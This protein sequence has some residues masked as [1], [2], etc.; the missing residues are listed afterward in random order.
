MIKKYKSSFNITSLILTL[1]LLSFTGNLKAQ[2]PIIF[3][4]D[5]V[6]LSLDTYRG[7][8][9]WQKAAEFSGNPV[10]WSDIPG[11]TFNNYWVKP[12]EHTYYRAKVTEGNCNPVVYSPEK[13]VLISSQPGVSITV[14]APTN[15]THSTADIA[16][17]VQRLGGDA[18]VTARGVCWGTS[19]NPTIENS[20]TINGTG[21]GSFNATLTG[22][23][24]NTT[25]YVRGYI[26]ANN[27]YS[28][29]DA[30]PPLIGYFTFKTPYRVKV[31]GNIVTETSFTTATLKNDISFN[32]TSVPIVSK[33]IVY[34]TV[35]DYRID[36]REPD[37]TDTKT[38]DGS[39][40]GSFTT[41]LTNL[42]SGG[43]Y[44]YRS[45]ATT[46]D[47]V[48]YYSD[49]WTFKTLHPLTAVLSGLGR[50]ESNRADI[51]ITVY[52]TGSYSEKGV[53][54]GLSPSPTI[55]GAISQTGIIHP[56]N[57]N[58]KYYARAYVIDSSGT[59][60]YGNEIPFTTLP[61]NS[62]PL[63]VTAYGATVEAGNVY[64]NSI[65]EGSGTVTNKGICYDV[66]EDQP[67]IVI[68]TD[69]NKT[70]EGP[71]SGAFS[72]ALKGL[73]KE[74]TYYYRAYAT[75]NNGTTIYSGYKY[76]F[77]YDFIDADV[78]INKIVSIQHNAAVF[79]SKAELIEGTGRGTISARGICYST[80]PNPSVGDSKVIAANSSGDIQTTITGLKPNTTYYAKAYVIV[81]AYGE[82][83][84]TYYSDEVSFTTFPSPVASVTTD[85]PSS[86]A[87]TSVVLGGKIVV[88]DII[89]ERGICWSLSPSPSILGNKVVE[90]AGAGSFT[91]TLTGL[92][93]GTK[94]YAKA[95][96]TTNSGSAM[97][98]DEVS[99]TTEITPITIST[100]T[101]SGITTNSA[102]S[103]GSV[104]LEGGMTVNERGICYGTAGGPTIS[105]SKTSNGQGAGTYTSTLTSLT[106][107]TTYYVRAYATDHTNK[108]HYGDE[109]SFTTP[110]A[111]T[112]Q[113]TTTPMTNI[114]LLTPTYSGTSGGT[115]SGTG[116]ISAKGVCWN[117]AENPTIANSKTTNGTGL[118]AFSS[119]VTG[120]NPG[121][122]YY[123]RAYA[124]N[125]TGT[126]VYGEQYSV[127]YAT[128]I[129]TELPYNVQGNTASSGGNIPTPASGTITA[130]GVCWGATENPTIANSKTSD[131]TGPGTFSS[132]LTGLIVNT[133][134]Y[135]RAY[136]TLSTGSTYYGNQ[137]T[138]TTYQAGTVSVT[139]LAASNLTDFSAE[140][141]GKVIGQ[142][143]IQARGICYGTIQNPSLSNKVITAYTWTTDY[144]FS[145]KATGLTENTV[146]YARAYATLSNGTTIYGNQV[147]FTTPVGPSYTI[148]TAPVTDIQPNWVMGG[149]TYSGPGTITD[150]GV[151]FGTSPN[152]VAYSA[153][154]GISQMPSETTT[155]Q[156]QLSPLQPNTVYYARAYIAAPSGKIFYGNQ[157]TFTSGNIE[158]KTA[159]STVSG[160][161][162]SLHGYIAL[163]S[164]GTITDKGICWSSTNT[165]PTTADSKSSQ[166]T[167]AGPYSTIISGLSPSTVYAFRAYAI[168]SSGTTIYGEVVGFITRDH[169]TIV[170]ETR[171]SFEKTTTSLLIGGEVVNEGSEVVTSRG[172]C[173]DASNPNPTTADSKVTSGSGN[174]AFGALLSGLQPSTRYYYRAYAVTNAGKTVY[175]RVIMGFTLTY[176][177]IP[178]PAPDPEEPTPPNNGGGTDGG[179]GFTPGIGDRYLMFGRVFGPAK[180]DCREGS[181]FFQDY[182]AYG[183]LYVEGKH[184]KTSYD[185]ARASLDAQMR[186]KYYGDKYTYGVESSADYNVNYR[187]AV[188]IEY[189]KKIT[190]WDCYSVYVTIGYGNSYDEALTHALS[191]KNKDINN[192]NKAPYKV[193]KQLHW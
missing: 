174:G 36:K 165:T 113:V 34:R 37:L 28:Y 32:G 152:P 149:G 118:S 177:N 74:G 161:S 122:T 67:I 1:F 50:L 108:T 57:P 89:T 116:T 132:S 6:K 27:L 77:F 110:V 148:T 49:G 19:I 158:V 154:T 45:Y 25:Y 120:L 117:T 63:T 162:A 127:Y 11:A 17:I 102:M 55:T 105:N 24:E 160:M 150:K 164:G 38:M 185:Q 186:A 69:N 104:I 128:T 141:S 109:V 192:G 82:G 93:P 84:S 61:L 23:Q 79:S 10:T 42:K 30:Q 133:T 175:G 78:Q 136:A 29:Y 59:V 95:Y 130:R 119:I 21:T 72:S 91:L 51:G 145:L 153:G 103:G 70:T 14:T 139:T 76:F 115:V 52:G 125:S 126:T 94:Y 31:T 159:G 179:G 107:N 147:S 137:R 181:N 92:T 65:I 131:G 138:L 146:Y 47:G 73:T 4:G 121:T 58:T 56:L 100:T 188:I 156:G 43:Y 68:T 22:L 114:Q 166:G 48:T 144:L 26:T 173:Y 129:T 41:N 183:I 191:R 112:F 184:T 140:I 5:S 155:F 170:V 169:A 168:T 46:A 71:G 54:Y 33:G 39:G 16:A 81:N 83:Y 88:S 193:L 62:Q 180:Q 98:G 178:P 2:N 86:I 40:S 182:K 123:Y 7:Q 20:K 151:T 80:E 157:I 143:N 3:K 75:L 135:V 142:E 99:F 106:A 187:Y 13:A 35:S 53:C 85:T 96:A 18:K 66:P 60:I 124:T 172:V 87:N 111:N 176:D 163:Y 12:T 167:A 90:G 64:T 190:G 8:V 189:K 134:Y 15:I 44:I 101:I 97:Y 9:V 171:G